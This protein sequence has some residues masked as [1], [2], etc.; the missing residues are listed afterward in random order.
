MKKVISLGLLITAMWLVAP[1]YGQEALTVNFSDP[2]R[3]GLLKVNIING[4]IIIR[5]HSRRDVI[6]EGRASNRPGGAF[7]RQGGP[8]GLRRIDNA[9]GLVIEEENN[10]M[11]ISTRLPGSSSDIEIQ[12]PSRTNLSLRTMN[13]GD[14][15]VEGVEGEIE[16]TN[17]NGAVVLNNVAGSVVAH[18]ANGRVQASLREITSS[19]KVPMSFTSMNGNIE[20]TL[21]ANAKANLKM[22]TDNGSTITEFEM[23]VR[24][25]PPTIEDTRNRGGRLRIETDRTLN[26]TI[27]GGGPEINLRTLNGNIYIRRGK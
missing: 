4:G 8:P 16:A 27:N 3:P 1:A 11:S 5:A 26:G 24:T 13:G 7:G 17:M 9:T 20:I 23:Q 21:P 14:I 10:V 22:R 12:V 19:S 25:N 15:V 18:S 6:I 2:S